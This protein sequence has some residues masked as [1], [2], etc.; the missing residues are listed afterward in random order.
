MRQTAKDILKMRNVFKGAEG[1]TAEVEV[2]GDALEI[3]IIPDTDQLALLVP[4]N[5]A[6]EKV[7]IIVTTA[8]LK[9]WHREG[10][11]G[12]S[13]MRRMLSGEGRTG[14]QDLAPYGVRRQRNSM[15]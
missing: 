3:N 15:R 14:F 7:S 13:L 11:E 5:E 1:K 12:K 10:Q 4:F 9:R 6:G 2:Q 8:V